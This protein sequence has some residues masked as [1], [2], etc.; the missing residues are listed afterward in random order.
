L[1]RAE[2]LERFRIVA[3]AAGMVSASGASSLT[4]TAILK[5][6]GSAGIGMMQRHFGGIGLLRQALAGRD[7][8][9]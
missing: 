1:T 3:V 4:T 8:E 5:A 7:G 9:G 6:M 2:A